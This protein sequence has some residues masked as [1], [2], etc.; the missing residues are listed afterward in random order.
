MTDRLIPLREVP[1]LDWLP[2]RR[3]GGRLSLSTLWRWCLRGV[4]AKDGQRVKLRAVRAGEVLC[5]TEQWVRDFFQALTEHDPDLA[6]DAGR[7]PPRTPGQRQ[8]AADRAAEK[9]EQLG[10]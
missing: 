7:A 5:T 10:I 4:R 9:L 1:K 8:R 2:V 6:A 3:G